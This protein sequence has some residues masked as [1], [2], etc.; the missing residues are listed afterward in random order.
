MKPKLKSESP[1]VQ[2]ANFYSAP[3]RSPRPSAFRRFAA[4]TALCLGTLAL[5]L[6]AT[7]IAFRTVLLDRFAQQPAKDRPPFFLLP[8]S[9]NDNRDFTYPVKK[10]P[11]TFRIVVVGDSF[12]FGGK[13]PF[14]DTFPK[15]LERM[16]KLNNEHRPVEVLN[17]GVPGLSTRQEEYGV[18]HALKYFQPD[19]IVLQVTLNDPEIRP[20]NKHLLSAVPDWVEALDRHW[21]SA[22]FVAHRLWNTV[23]QKR[24]VQYY[25][26][27][28]ENE[29]TKT[30]FTTGASEIIQNAR[31]AGVPLVAAIFP[32]FSHTVDES[33]PFR[34]LHN[35]ID[36]L[37]GTL[38]IPHVDL[39]SGYAGI[40][41]DR[42]AAIPGKDPHPN[43]IAH[44][45]A[46]EQ[47][48]EF[49]TTQHLLPED[50][51]ARRRVPSRP[52]KGKYPIGNPDNDPVDK[53]GSAVSDSHLRAD[54]DVLGE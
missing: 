40:P 50:L 48:Y 4:N 12:T 35:Y 45:I 30:N 20:L 41:A 5:L 15:R 11:G 7:E 18:R 47:I 13:C 1:A 27:L 14:D 36:S 6:G 49:L 44:R 10:A 37:F 25:F 42:L 9:S 17:W 43:E 24:Y 32:V 53:D 31:A 33:Y 34:P 51:V 52:L 22:G 2:P 3:K 23:A 21:V 8:E 38:G 29:D 28:F 16:L 54:A 46:A 39:M 26:S 19:L